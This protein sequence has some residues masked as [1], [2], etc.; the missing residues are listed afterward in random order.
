SARG[1]RSRVHPQRG[2]ERNAIDSNGRGGDT[3]LEPPIHGTSGA[4]RCRPVS[5]IFLSAP[6]LAGDELQRL[7]AAIS[8]GWVAPLGPEVDAFEREMCERLGVPA[9]VA[10]SSGTAALHLA[11]L[12]L[13]VEAG[14]S[15]WCS[16]LT[17][18]A[19]ANAI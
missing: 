15:V 2:R 10:V 5:R 16:T 4:I 14:D 1:G 13:G 19:T 9:A 6:D 18:A 12:V 8:S 3:A 17:F 7:Q 11:L